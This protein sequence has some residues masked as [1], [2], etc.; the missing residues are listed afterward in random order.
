MRYKAVIFDLD[1]TL[2]NTIEDIA[3]SVNRVLAQHG[4]PEHSVD[5]FQQMVG[6]GMDQLIFDALPETNRDQATLAGV[7]REASE[8]Y[9]KGWKNKTVPY[10]GVPELLQSLKSAGV[11]VA[12]LSNKPDRFTQLCVDALLPR[13]LLDAV[14]GA[15][16]DLPKK[17]APDGALHLAKILKVAPSEVLYVGD[18]GTDMKTAKAAGMFAVGVAWGF[19]SEAELREDGADR[20][21][22]KPQ[23][24]MALI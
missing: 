3:D 24:L 12:I 9:A 4:F 23:E 10:A 2:L 8:V 5:R 7:T 19:R 14:L 13:P 22:H 20:I 17:P 11:K 6:L 21:I 16:E 18:S 1:G 15:R